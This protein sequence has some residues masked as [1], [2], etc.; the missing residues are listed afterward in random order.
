[1]LLNSFFVVLSPLPFFLLTLG[2]LLGVTIGAI[3]GL[4]GVMLISLSLPLTFFMTPEN[5]IILLIGM[6]VGSISGGLISA[7]LL[8]MPG[9]PA[10][11]MTTLDGFPMAQSGRPGRA[12]GLGI[13]AS[14]IGGII[15]WFF[16]VLLSR[17]LAD[18]ATRF[19]PFEFFSLTLVSMVVI[20]SISQGTM[21]KG[22]I[23]AALGT[24]V[25]MPGVDPTVGTQRLNFG[26]SELDGGFKLMPVLVGV[27]VVSQLF[28]GVFKKAQSITRLE[29]KKSE[30][31]LNL[32]EW[33]GQAVN[34][35]RSSL[36]GTWVGILPGIGANIGSILSYS[37]AR[38]MSKRPELF[39]TGSEEGIVASEAANNATVG[40]AL[41]PLI[42]MGIPGS[43]IDAI[44][45][46]ALTIHSIVPGPLLFVNN[47]ELVYAMMSSA[48]VANFVMFAFMFLMVGYIAKV[49]VV[50]MKYLLPIIAVFCVIGAFAAGNRAFDVWV[51]LGFGLFGFLMERLSY[52][53][54]PFVI[55]MILAP[56][57]ETSLRSGLMIS[58]GSFRPLIERPVSATLILI[59]IAL[60]LWPF[61]KN[62]KNK[63]RGPRKTDQ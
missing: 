2:T 8:K 12:I 24:M 58:G 16:L 41:I 53:L 59:S 3:P 43:V 27:F 45:I 40:G 7:T 23:A 22:L 10:A 14:L 32:K 44:L 37:T 39:G 36:I 13:S 50:P 34:L 15:S 25:A 42:A 6:Y 54:A 46:G 51:M 35:V 62:R 60:L 63:W 48:L 1:M 49:S 47:P 9:T 19:S 26:F 57:A 56:I 17:P 11:V 29:M 21:V 5:G 55:G 20:A 31:F 52:P 4:T 30:L 28:D 38:N 18:I 61:I 33:R